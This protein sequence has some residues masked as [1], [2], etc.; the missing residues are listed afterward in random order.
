METLILLPIVGILLYLIIIKS[1]Y[2]AK[3]E[4]F[5]SNKQTVFVKRYWWVFPLLLIAVVIFQ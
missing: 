2:M 3:A 5:K 4:D 1:Y